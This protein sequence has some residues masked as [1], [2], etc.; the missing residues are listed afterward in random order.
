MAD[1]LRM[2]VVYSVAQ[3]ALA[4]NVP[5]IAKQLLLTTVREKAAQR[6]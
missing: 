2:S 5:V 3:I 4:H 6:S 1:D